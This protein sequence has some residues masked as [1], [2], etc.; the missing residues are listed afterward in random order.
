MKT[1]PLVVV[2]LSFT[3]YIHAQVDTVFFEDFQ[4]D[5]F[6]IMD[7][8][9]T[10]SNLNWVNFDEDG[11]ATNLGTEES[12]QWYGGEANTNTVDTV[13]GIT[14][15]VAISSSFLENFLPGNRNWMI[16]PPQEITNDSYVFSWKSAPGQ[17]PRYMDGYQVLISTIGNDLTSFTDTLFT[18]ASM[19]QIVGDGDST[20]F[21]NFTFTPGYIHASGGTDANY[22]L[23]GTTVNFGVLEP[24]SVDLSAYE[25]QTVYLAFLHDSDD[26]ERIQIDDI[27]LTKAPG[28]TGIGEVED[29]YSMEV[30]PNP[31]DQF[32]NLDFELEQSKVVS[33]AV[34]NT[35]GKL[36]FASDIKIYLPGIHNIR[37]NLRYVPAGL[38]VIQLNVEDEVYNRGILKR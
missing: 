12:L 15:F 17:L 23:E 10:G 1:P 34:Y 33:Y 20:D 38:Y 21:S 16:L 5:V 3:I 7:N 25:G 8:D 11:L 31:A 27:L 13:T 24:H 32:V 19:D 2:L 35:L 9:P 28:S 6:Q 37:A 36:V 26:D 22:Y 18:A 14:N 29:K 4:I 30:Y